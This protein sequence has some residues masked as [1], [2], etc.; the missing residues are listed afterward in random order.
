MTLTNIQPGTFVATFIGLIIAALVW[1]TATGTRVP[2]LGSERATLVAVVVLGFA[3]CIAGGWGATTLSTTP[4][5]VV[6]MIAGM[7]TLFVLGAVIFNWSAILDPLA[8]VMYGTN[9]SAVADRV[10]VITVGVLI[11]IAWLAAT[12]RQLGFFATA[13]S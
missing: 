8:G 6:A 9:S 12:I 3:M 4:L 10:G 13:T 5:S 11:A 7:S 1:A 2:V